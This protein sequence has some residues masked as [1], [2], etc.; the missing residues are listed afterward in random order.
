MRRIVAPDPAGDLLRSRLSV[1]GTSATVRRVTTTARSRHAA[2]VRSRRRRARLRARR[3]A[4]L[5]FLGVLTIVTLLLTAFG[6]SSKEPLP[7]APASSGVVPGGRPE[8]Q[9]LA[10]VGN[11][12]IKLPVAAGSVTAIGFHGSATGA[13]SLQPLGPQANE[14]LLARLWHRIAGTSKHGPAWFQLGGQAGPGT[15]VLDVGAAPGTDVYAPVDG[16]IA[17]ISDYI[18][19]G[20][21]QGSRID[22]RPTAAPS[23]VLSLTH[24][25]PDPSLA[26]GTS[27]NAGSSKIGSVIDISKVER[28]ALA[29]HT[30]DNGDNVAIEVHSAPTSLP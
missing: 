8:P 16:T 11:L 17:A 26:V 1:S 30:N 6:T 15:G 24:L 22:I 9:P 10:T 7:V 12:T 5:V 20:G 14:G 19:N 21:R 13:L 18:V 4:V 27:V 23:V 2:R 29:S 3:I 28:Q 25:E